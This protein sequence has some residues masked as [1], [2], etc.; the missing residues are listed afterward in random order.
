MKREGADGTS[1]PEWRDQ[2]SR[3][4]VPEV[5]RLVEF[6]EALPIVVSWLARLPCR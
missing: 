4:D 2:F 3:L 5:D 6:S 1:R